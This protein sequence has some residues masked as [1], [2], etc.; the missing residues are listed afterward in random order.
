MLFFRLWQLQ[1]LG[2]EK[3]QMYSRT[4]RIRLIEEPAPRGQIVDRQG[5]IL[6]SNRPSFGVYAIPADLR[7]A[8]RTLGRLSSILDTP[9][10][11]LEEK[12]GEGKMIP[13]QP[14]PLKGD[15]DME[16]VAKIEEQKEDLPGIIVRVQPLRIYPGGDLA[17]H[18][19]GY[20]G[21][22][23]KEQLVRNEYKNYKGGDLIGQYGLER[24]FNSQ[25]HGINGGVEIEV[26][27]LGREVRTVNQFTPKIGAAVRL[28]IDKRLQRAAERAMTGQKGAV[29]AIDPDSG[30]I[31]ALLSKPSFNPNMFSSKVSVEDW[32]KMAQDPWRPMYNRALMSQY[33][34]GS[35]FK[36]INA[37]AALESGAAT[38][39]TAF[40]CSGKFN[41][42]SQEFKCWN[43]GGH[44]TVDLYH[45]I[46][47]SCNVYHY[48]LG[49]RTGIDEIAR[50]AKE[51]GL[52]APVGL[53]IGDEAKGLVPTPEW[54]KKAYGGEWYS[55]NTVITSIG[56]GM[57]LTTPLQ[58]A[59]A[60]AAIANGG[61]LYKPTVIKSLEA[62]DGEV[63]QQFEPQV[64]RQVNISAETLAFLRKA[65]W[66]VVNDGGTGS[67]AFIPKVGVSGK[68]GTA[69][70]VKITEARKRAAAR[71]VLSVRDHAWF[72]CFA[73]YEHPQV[74]LV[75]FV[76]HGGAGGQ[77]AAPI[78]KQIL[79]A[80][81]DI[82][83]EPPASGSDKEAPVSGTEDLEGE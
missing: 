51:L 2:K 16:T 25:L 67:K 73:P 3:Y 82:K 34:P 57:I 10:E 40:R 17:S 38:P 36:L 14:L 63:L 41:L 18:L 4:S 20:L 52:G 23:T 50:V 31:L 21:E 69:Q 74:A 32:Q 15:V 27:A 70:V 6:V 46:T 83:K 45:S 72:V 33:P 65:M 35:V 11:E 62:E 37:A 49:L 66:G 22:I 44:G 47:Q 60:V 78:A 7:E 26:N 61:T 39:Q 28:T 12:V 24:A 55:G 59:N 75:V 53:G 42:G 13:Y 9:L 56:Q 58:L 76:E 19:F 30:E 5:E 68:T 77:A 29:V 64:I 71:G 79:E 80:Y 1:V 48:Q 8:P 54:K 81:L 43:K